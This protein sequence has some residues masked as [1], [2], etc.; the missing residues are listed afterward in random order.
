L[1]GD[2]IKMITVDDKDNDNEDFNN[3][4]TEHNKATEHN[5]TTVI[6]NQKIFLIKQS[7]T[8]CL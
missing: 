8:S 4:T 6:I 5:N 3:D 2:K 7:S 1:E